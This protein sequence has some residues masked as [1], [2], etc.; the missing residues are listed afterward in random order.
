MVF[1]HHGNDD[2]LKFDHH[3]CRDE[4]RESSLAA[5]HRDEV[6]RCSLQVFRCCHILK[7][8]SMQLTNLSGAGRSCNAASSRLPRKCCNQHTHC[9]S[10]FSCAGRFH[11]RPLRPC[12]S[13]C[14]QARDPLFSG[15]FPPGNT[16]SVRPC[17]ISAGQHVY[18]PAQCASSRVS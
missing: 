1:P 2:G 5:E 16:S 6:R 8:P 12:I 13:L 4:V 14:T 3:R 15:H 18:N 9:L 7:S 11:W 17:R 10:C